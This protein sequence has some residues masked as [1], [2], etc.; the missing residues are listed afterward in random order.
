[1]NAPASLSFY[2]NN[3]D[4]ILLADIA[5]KIQLTQSEYDDAVA[6]Y[7]AIETYL[8]REDSPLKGLV[9]RIYPQGSMR[10]NATISSTQDTEEFDIDLIVELD[11][12]HDSDPEWVLQLLYQA[13]RGKP[14]SRYYSN[15]KLNSRCV[16]IK[17]RNMHLDLCPAVLQIGRPDRTST[18]FHWNK[19]RGERERHTRNPWGFGD[20]FEQSLLPEVAF[21]SFYQARGLA[22]LRA[23]TEPV[24]EPIPVYQ[25]PR[26]V[27]AL[28]LIKR[29][30]NH[31]FEGR[32]VRKPPSVV[33][34]KYAIHAGA[35]HGGLLA[36]LT[37]QVDHLAMK[38]GGPDK[39]AETNPS[40]IE[41]VL[42]DRWP[43]SF[44][45]QRLYYR[46]VR[47]FQRQLIALRR[48]DD[49]KEKQIIL[50]DL[51]GERAT[52]AAFES[53]QRKYSDLSDRGL[54][55]VDRGTAG[56]AVGASGIAGA[57]AI[58]RGAVAAPRHYSHARGLERWRR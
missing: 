28:Q 33:L 38:L 16:T 32:A 19:E 50:A 13:I 27:V 23:E 20:W 56:L 17:Y 18:M 10:I 54:V 15:T 41:D 39:I 55:H 14:G 6:H 3:L 31:K 4:E 47:H 37:G 52:T 7:S 36:E 8:N 49:L 45:D 2:Q 21:M 44:E 9:K 48:A 57:P 29:S 58:S 34:S 30:R 43:S 40:C 42:T 22:V 46:D 26:K 12:P 24:P 1:M 53:L 35:S 25:K 11:L 5:V 51:F